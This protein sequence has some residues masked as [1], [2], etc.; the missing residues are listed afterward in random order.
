ML[1][2]RR[3]RAP[4][5]AAS[6]A[7]SRRSSTRSRP[8]AS[9]EISG[10]D[11]KLRGRVS[12]EPRNFVAWVYADPKGPEHNTLNCSIS[13]LELEIEQPRPRA[14]APRARAAPRPTRSGCARPTTA[15]RSSPTPTAERDAAASSTCAVE[16]G[17]GALQAE[18]GLEVR[19]GRLRAAARAD[20]PRAHDPRRVAALQHLDLAE[21]AREQ[22]RRAGTPSRPASSGPSR[23]GRARCRRRDP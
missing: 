7:S 19:A 3:R 22:P 2:H 23:C 13:D 1:L 12:S 10:K 9:F 17:P 15:S 5:R 14:A 20:H 18:P 11:V 21:P 8:A 6:T 4:A 16:A